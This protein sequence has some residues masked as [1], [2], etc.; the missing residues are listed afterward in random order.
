[1]ND[2]E[3]IKLNINEIFYSIQGESTLAGLPCVFIRLQGCNLRCD[4]CDTD[5]ALEINKNENIKTCDEIINVVKSYSCNYVCLTGGEPLAQK[6]VV[7]L[8]DY[9]VENQYLVSLE[10]NGS[11]LLENIDK[12]IKK[13]VDFKTP[14]S[15]MN[16]FNNFD[17]ID[18]LTLNDEVKFVVADYQDYLW[19]LDI[20]KRYNLLRKV[21]SVLMSTV[22]DRLDA[23]EL[24]NWIMKDKIPIRLQLQLHK[25]LWN[26]MQRGV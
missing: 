2:I 20:I 23:T 3:N 24:A 12:R 1:M 6:D 25:I 21:N 10:T 11:Y 16:K 5:Y 18:Y 4:W 17:N 22:F 7:F 9:F 19:S 15:K 8:M 26:P 13:V 14:S